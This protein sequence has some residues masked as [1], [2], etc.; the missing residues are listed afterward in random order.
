MRNLGNGFS[1]TT[2]KS[3]HFNKFQDVPP[4]Y[5]LVNLNVSFKFY[6]YQNKEGLPPDWVEYQIDYQIH[7]QFIISTCY[8]ICPLQFV[9]AQ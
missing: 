9:Y 2:G 5:E 1:S 3:M 4:K 6:K 7:A 8:S